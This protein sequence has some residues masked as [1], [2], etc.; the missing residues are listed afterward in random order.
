MP[1]QHWPVLMR[2]FGFFNSPASSRFSRT[3]I[4]AI[5]LSHTLSQSLLFSSLSNSFAMASQKKT[6]NVSS[7]TSHPII[8]SSPPAGQAPHSN[9]LKP[10]PRRTTTTTASRAS[11]SA[12]LLNSA[13]LQVYLRSGEPVDR[14]VKAQFTNPHHNQNFGNQAQPGQEVRRDDGTEALDQWMETVTTQPELAMGYGDI[15]SALPSMAQIYEALRLDDG[16]AARNRQ[17]HTVTS[18]DSTQPVLFCYRFLPTSTV[19]GS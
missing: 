4:L 8:P 14:L 9:A 7:S 11:Y 10:Y 15:N 18:E 16:G 19:R 17:S 3:R 2:S 13:P 5:T 1:F 12:A 6:Q